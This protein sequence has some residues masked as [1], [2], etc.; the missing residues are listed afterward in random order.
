MIARLQTFQEKREQGFT[1]IELLIVILIIGILS[2]I[3]I[4]AFMNQRKVAVDA[5]TQSDIRS[6]VTEIH[7]GLI[8]HKDV[9]CIS[10][11]RNPAEAAVTIQFHKRTEGMN[12]GPGHKCDPAPII[13]ETKV[14]LSE[15]TSIGAYGDP[16][17]PEGFFVTGWN[18]GGT[19]NDS[20]P[21]TYYRYK[22]EIGGFI[23][24]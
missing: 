6:V 19:M 11:L 10:Q 15:G 22:S 23:E 17:S 20:L 18:F 13:G 14:S 16:R 7:T 2:A 8:K 9:G 24:W 5:S 1:L 12:V 4:P 21:G 3:A